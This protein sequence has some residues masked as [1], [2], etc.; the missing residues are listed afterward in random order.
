MKDFLAVENKIEEAVV[1]GIFPGAVLLVSERGKLAF[2]R[3]FG[4][5]SILPQKEIMTED[6]VFDIASVTKVFATT[7]TIMILIK[8][9]KISLEDRVSG[10]ISEF[11]CKEKEEI[12]IRHLLNH[13][14]GMPDWLPLYRKWLE[15]KDDSIPICSKEARQY[16]YQRINHEPTAYTVGEKFKYSDIGFL[17]L[18]E[19][20]EIL[21]GDILDKFCE[22]KIFK[23][24]SLSN[25]SFL[26]LFEPDDNL[27]LKH[28]NFFFASTENCPWRNKTLH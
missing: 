22:E 13:C 27:L 5:R 28:K 9:G 6:T 7:T 3:A 1:N 26:N 12:T 23:P 24:L 10:F 20:I 21:A 15:K 4:F 16:I 2:H 25:T 18:G 19:I 17:I 11:N 14:S 8:E